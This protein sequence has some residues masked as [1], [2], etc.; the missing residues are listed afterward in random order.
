MT[1]SSSLLSISSAVSGLDSVGQ[2][3]QL[4]DAYLHDIAGSQETR[5][6]ESDADAS[7]RAGGDYIPGLQCDAGGDGGDNGR[8]IEDQVSRG[9]VLPKFPIDPALDVE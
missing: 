3:P 6:L 5:R 4:I 7:G 1:A 9:G 2:S 8:Y